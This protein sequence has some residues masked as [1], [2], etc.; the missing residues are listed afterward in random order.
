[1]IAAPSDLRARVDAAVRF[2]LAR[3]KSV[4]IKRSF[5]LR[6][7]EG[8]DVSRRTLFRW[9]DAAI[10][11]WRPPDGAMEV[12]VPA[13][14]ERGGALRMVLEVRI[15]AAPATTPHGGPR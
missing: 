7:F 12:I 5:V 13:G 10:K 15:S 3:A 2:E 4:R 1:M 9:A 14:V 11:A 6:A 8:E